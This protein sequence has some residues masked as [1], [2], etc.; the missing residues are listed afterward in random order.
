MDRKEELLSIQCPITLTQNVITGKWKLVI[1][2]FLKKGV[3]RFNTLQ[4]S[5]PGVQRAYLTQQLRELEQ[6]GI[7]HR[8]VYKVVPPKV[9]Y[10]LTEIGL[11]FCSVLDNISAWGK[12]YMKHIHTSDS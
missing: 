10:S 7:I 4:K 6:D 3:M 2:F 8:E 11:S 12:S 1:I 5:I 9:E